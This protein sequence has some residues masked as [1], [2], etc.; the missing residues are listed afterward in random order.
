MAPPP[1]ENSKIVIALDYDIH[2]REDSVVL[3]SSESLQTEREYLFHSKDVVGTTQTL[4]LQF[5]VTSDQSVFTVKFSRDMTEDSFLT[6]NSRRNTGMRLTWHYDQDD[7]ASTADTTDMM[8]SNKY[9]IQLANIV[10]Q[11]KDI[12][13][14]WTSLKSSRNRFLADHDDLFSLQGTC[15]DSA[16]A[17]VLQ[18]LFELFSDVHQD[19]PLTPVHQQDITEESLS[20]AGEM[21]F[22]LLHC[23]DI[24]SENVPLLHFY[25]DLFRQVSL[26]TILMTLARFS[27][28]EGTSANMRRIAADFFKRLSVEVDFHYRD[29]DAFTLNL[30]VEGSVRTNITG[31]E[32]LSRLINHPVH[33]TTDRDVLSPSAFIPFC[34]FGG[35]MS[36]L[37]RKID[38][39]SSPVCDAFKEHILEDQLCYELDVNK[40]RSNLSS[41]MDIN[42]AMKIG[43]FL[44]VDKELFRRRKNK[45]I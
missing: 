35:E 21:Y 11:S 37:G 16:G 4:S 1:G 34:A 19:I 6:W 25:N 18:P 32:M 9:F 2:S 27:A 31:D 33:I 28:D 23:P 20:V 17:S 29:I 43:I 7:Q 26:K 8:E 15:R 5:P 14:V 30:P 42:T 40:Y 39:F 38:Q 41:Q 3:Y 44:L 12:A 13:E 22:Y 36:P 45:N 24:T 10:H